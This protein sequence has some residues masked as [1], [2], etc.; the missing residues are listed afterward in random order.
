MN[1]LEAAVMRHAIKKSYVDS[2]VLDV[3]SN[4]LAFASNRE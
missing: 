2:A 3:C 1:K 4:V